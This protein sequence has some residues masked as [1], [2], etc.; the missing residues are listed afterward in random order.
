MTNPPTDQALALV[1]QALKEAQM[2]DHYWTDEQFGVAAKELLAKL[3]ALQPEP[4]L[5]EKLKAKGFTPPPEN[6]EQPR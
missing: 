3:A 4:G 2:V 5:A 6:V 1:F